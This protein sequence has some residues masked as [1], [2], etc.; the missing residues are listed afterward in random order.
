MPGRWPGGSRLA[1]DPDGAG[2]AA[3]F[4]IAKP[5][6]DVRSLRL[7]AIFRWEFRPGS[8]LFLVWT[9]QR[10]DVLPRDFRLRPDASARLHLAAG[11]C[12]HGEGELLVGISGRREAVGVEGKGRTSPNRRRNRRGGF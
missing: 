5:D 11:R 4:S 1:I 2:P 3:G 6:F 12:V 7:I 10:R 9:Q 8:S